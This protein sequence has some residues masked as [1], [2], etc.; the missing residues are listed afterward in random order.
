MNLNEQ[1]LLLMISVLNIVERSVLSQLASFWLGR[2]VAF[3]ALQSM[4]RQFAA[5]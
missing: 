5:P 2:S 3:I 1:K 4:L